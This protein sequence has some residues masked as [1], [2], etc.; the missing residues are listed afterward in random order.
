[1]IGLPAGSSW[2]I[3]AN[4]LKF[5]LDSVGYHNEPSRAEPSQPRGERA[6]EHEVFHLVI[7]PYSGP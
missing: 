1:M 7:A 3:I 2:L 6:N 4:K 5:W